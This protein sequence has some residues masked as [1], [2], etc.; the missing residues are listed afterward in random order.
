MENEIK[1]T[2]IDIVS[3]NVEK[4]I[5]VMKQFQK[6]KEQIL[7]NNDTLIISGKKYI[8]RSGWRKIAL[9]FNIST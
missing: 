2:E 8:K 4:S 1:K 7:D 5:Q 9:A 6:L 3:P